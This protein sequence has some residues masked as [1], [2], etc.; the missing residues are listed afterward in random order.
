M[1]VT[2]RFIKYVR[3]HTASSEESETVP[4]TSRQFDLAR[5]LA[6][7]MRQL[8]FEN[9]YEDEHAYVYGELP[10]TEG[11]ESLPAI[12]F[13][14]HVDTIPDFS[15]ENVNPIIT[16]NYNGEDFP[17]GDSG[18]VIEK[19]M[20]EHLSSLKGQT[21]IT[22]DGTTVL[23]ADDK[24][25]IAEIMT[26]FENLIDGNIP[27]RRVIAVFSPDEEVG[28]GAALMDLDRVN[29]A[30]G[31]TVDGGEP[32][33]INYE[34]FNA[35]A[36]R[37]E[38]KGFNIHPGDAKDKMINANC[39][40]FEINSMLPAAEVPEKTEN[41]EGFYHL[42][43][44]KGTVES[45]ELNYIVRDHDA[46][47]FESKIKTLRLIEK[48]INEKYG[49]GTAVL[50]I[51]NQYRNM[52]ELLEKQFYIVD[53]AKDAIRKEGMT[54]V[55]V[56]IRGGTDGSQLSFRGLLCPNLGTGGYACH[57]PYEHITSERMEQCVRVILNI[58]TH[59]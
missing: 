30:F 34:T 1:T 25:G 57:G 59:E 9:V 41:Y 56:P 6:D 55:T 2:E 46:S 15:G 27:H 26:A 38:I 22:T 50:T 40:A 43:S 7:E 21:L 37:W 28:H 5:L 14:A 29:A 45:A 35:A 48:T 19:S 4:T 42:F 12:A 31:F 3:I 49:P 20:F 53:M 33:E 36:A 23:G 39:V 58:I 13:N 16:E 8:G 44:M 10:A 17:L 54:P 47:L 51:V 52:A 24:A 11:Y 32:Y 18:R